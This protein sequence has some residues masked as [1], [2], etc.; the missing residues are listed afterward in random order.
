[1]RALSAKSIVEAWGRGRP[2]TGTRRPIILLAAALRERDESR[3]RSLTVGERDELL[4]ALRRR[5]FGPTLTCRSEC[6]GCAATLTF[7]LEIDEILTEGERRSGE[8]EGRLREHG[9][10]VRFRAPTVEDLAAAVAAGDVPRGREVLLERCVFEARRGSKPVAASELPGEVVEA[11]SRRLERLDP[12]AEVPVEL[13]CP[14]CGRAW[15]PILDIGAF[16]WKEVA[17]M[18]ERLMYDVHLL[19]R[20]YGW[21]E[22]SILTMGSARRKRYRDLASPGR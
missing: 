9:H 12:L 8:T 16:F 15:E 18:A 10:D 17:A 1:M 7:D 5:T 22:E 11:L 13:E 14:E 3:L 21:S 4:L 19:A 6:P 20:F 2:A